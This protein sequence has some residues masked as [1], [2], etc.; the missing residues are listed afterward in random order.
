MQ[1]VK[2][3]LF[4]CNSLKF[5][6]GSLLASKIMALVSLPSSCFL[7]HQCVYF[8]SLLTVHRLS[9]I[10]RPL[11]Y[12]E[13]RKASM[14]AKLPHF[15]NSLPYFPWLSHTGAHT[16]VHTQSHTR[17]QVHKTITPEGTGRDGLI[18]DTCS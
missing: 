12:M 14:A 7:H 17:T 18:L 10:N 11:K 8:C 4:V 15:A 3:F 9:F 1:T 16:N 2:K 6:N 5:V 13:G